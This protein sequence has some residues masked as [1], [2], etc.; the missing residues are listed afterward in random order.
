MVICE[1]GHNGDN[2]SQQHPGKRRSKLR[3]K[4]KCWH[5]V[6]VSTGWGED[7]ALAAVLVEEAI[8]LGQKLEILPHVPLGMLFR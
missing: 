7:A 3:A 8:H 1:Y 4:R 6:H 5:A 2:N